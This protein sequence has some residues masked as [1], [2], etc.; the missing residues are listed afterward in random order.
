MKLSQRERLAQFILEG[1]HTVPEWSRFQSTVSILKLKTVSQGKVL[2]SVNGE[3]FERPEVWLGNFQ[4]TLTS[5]WKDWASKLSRVLPKERFDELM[6]QEKVSED[7]QAISLHDRL[8]KVD[9]H[10]VENGTGMFNILATMLYQ[11]GILN[12]YDARTFVEEY[13]LILKEYKKHHST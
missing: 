8:M 6:S 13:Q 9:P 5:Q 2:I 11:A 1:E 7:Q 12:I 3:E 4:S 10:I